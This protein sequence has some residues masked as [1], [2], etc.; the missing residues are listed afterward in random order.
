MLQF[1][2]KI[3]EHNFWQK[4]LAWMESDKKS[5]NLQCV[6]TY[7]LNTY[8]SLDYL[9]K[10]SCIVISSSVSISCNA[11]KGYKRTQTFEYKFVKN[12]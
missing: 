12:K 9:N 1:H 10:T 8:K 2:E 7:Y 5:E 6:S 3:L 11:V 4:K